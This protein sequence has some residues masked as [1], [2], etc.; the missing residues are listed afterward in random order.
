MFVVGSQVTSISFRAGVAPPILSNSAP[1]TAPA[2]SAMT[3]VIIRCLARGGR[4][5]RVNVRAVPLVACVVTLEPCSEQLPNTTW[6]KRVNGLQGFHA[7]IPNTSG[8]GHRS[9]Q[10]SGCYMPIAVT[11][12]WAP[13]SS[14]HSATGPNCPTICDSFERVRHGMN[15]RCQWGSSERTN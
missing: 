3:P 4:S 1:H 8:I 9:N 5:K 7:G 13:H 2:A 14:A 12:E 11:P 15:M 6:I 10:G